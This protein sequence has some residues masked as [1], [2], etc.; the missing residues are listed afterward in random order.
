VHGKDQGTG[1]SH[2]FHAAGAARELLLV[3]QVRRHGT[4][5]GKC[6]VNIRRLVGCN[7]VPVE[8]CE[9]AA[10]LIITS[11]DDDDCAVFV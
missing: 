8:Q 4:A 9:I 10:K 1:G 6:G 7:S 3:T 5:Y 2:P 11:C